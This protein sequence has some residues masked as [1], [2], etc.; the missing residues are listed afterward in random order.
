[1]YI[2]PLN[3]GEYCPYHHL[4]KIWDRMTWD[5]EDRSHCR[6][7]D[8]KQERVVLQVPALGGILCSRRMKR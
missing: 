8:F 1:M 6:I 7:A 3:H 4:I 5:E 2:Y